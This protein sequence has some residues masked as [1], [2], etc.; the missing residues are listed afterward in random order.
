LFSKDSFDY[1]EETDQFLCPSGEILS[2]K[3]EYEYNIKH[4]LKFREFLTRGIENVRI[5]HNLI[6]MAH[7]LKV[8]WGKLG[9]SVAALGNIAGFIANFASR[10]VTF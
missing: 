4:N 6:C 3:G 7:N 2:R 1:D 10:V 5:E 8:M 9:S